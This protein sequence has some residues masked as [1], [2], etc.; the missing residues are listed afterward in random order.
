MIKRICVDMSCSIIHNGHVRLLKKA[1]KF[2]KVV[3]ALTSDADIIKYKKIT[4]EL[5]FKQRK[6]NNRS[7]IN[8]NKL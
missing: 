8:I 2:G 3:V 5:N 7:I 6:E 1:N 4:P